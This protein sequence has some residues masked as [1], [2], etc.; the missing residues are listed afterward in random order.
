MGKL[1]TLA[2]VRIKNHIKEILMYIGETPDREGLK[3]TPDR[4]VLMLAEI[5]RGYSKS[6]KPKITTFPNGADGLTYSDIIIDSGKF[7][8]MCEHHMMPFFGT[9]HF[10]YIPHPKGKILGLSKIARV[11][12]FHAARLQIQERLI[13]D[14]VTDIRTALDC[15]HKPLGIAIK[16]T[17]EHLCKS[18][19]GVKKQGV[20]TNIYREGA[21]ENKEI[22]N[23]FLELTKDLQ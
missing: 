12:D 14:I 23:E 9:Y 11:V 10:A 20:M 5:F 16:I 21:F 19:R 1:E 15:N 2:D 18:M 8:S 22:M 4:I 3:D 17:A 6:Q 7:Y 13:T